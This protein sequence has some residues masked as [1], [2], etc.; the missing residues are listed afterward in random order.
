MSKA[1]AQD[2]SSLGPR[3]SIAAL[4]PSF[5]IAQAAI[6]FGIPVS[7]N[8]IVVS[9]VVGAGYVAGGSAG[10]SRSKMGYTVLAW[11]GSLAL[12]IVLAYMV[13][14]AVQWVV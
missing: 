7:F 2:Y 10:V 6:L 1:I 9:A 12:S 8:E 13:L 14:T 4:I 5:A 3:R 11:I